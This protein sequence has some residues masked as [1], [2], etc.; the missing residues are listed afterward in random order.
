VDAQSGVERPQW[1]ESRERCPTCG[2][3]VIVTAAKKLRKHKRQQDGRWHMVPCAGS[4]A[5][6]ES[7]DAPEVSG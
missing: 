1:A 2:Q 3:W 7:Q 4:G 5:A 6:V